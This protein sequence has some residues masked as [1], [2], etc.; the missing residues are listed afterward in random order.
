MDFETISTATSIGFGLTNGVLMCWTVWRLFKAVAEF[1]VEVIF[2]AISGSIRG[3]GWC[4]KQV[5][6]RL[7][8]RM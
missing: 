3:V 5:R 1:F 2:S 8:A 4:V 7:R 6:Q